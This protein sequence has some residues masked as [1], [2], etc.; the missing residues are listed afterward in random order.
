MKDRGQMFL[1]LRAVLIHHQSALAP[2]ERG[3]RREGV[4]TPI[5]TYTLNIQHSTLLTHTLSPLH[6]CILNYLLSSHYQLYE[7][8][9]AITG[10][11]LLIFY[12]SVYSIII[13]H[14]YIICNLY[15]QSKI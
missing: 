13:T 15:N 7:I 3:G 1:T 6:S 2:Q 4:I 9:F 12:I 11:H 5:T 14:Y 10:T 8:C